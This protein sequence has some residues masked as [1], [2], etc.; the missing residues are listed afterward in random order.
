MKAYEV[1]SSID[2]KQKLVEKMIYSGDKQE[3]RS[4]VG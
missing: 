2:A 4:L 1:V 3:A